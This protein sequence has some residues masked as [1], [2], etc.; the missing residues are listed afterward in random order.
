M[1]SFVLSD[2]Y[3][4]LLMAFQAFVVVNFFAQVMTLCTIAHPF[5]L[6]VCLR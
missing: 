4:D 2:Q 5:Q 3:F 6:G 1:I